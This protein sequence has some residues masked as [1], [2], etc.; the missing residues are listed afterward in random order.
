MNNT[1]TI[2]NTYCISTILFLQNINIKYYDT[3]VYMLCY[4]VFNNNRY[5]KYF[6]S[7][8]GKNS[9]SHVIGGDSK[10]VIDAEYKKQLVLLTLLKF[11]QKKHENVLYIS[12]NKNEI[13]IVNKIN[14]CHTYYVKT[15]GL[16]P[17]DLQSILKK[18]FNISE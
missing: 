17:N 13:D 16:T 6:T 10:L 3:N 8:M 11:L 1:Y 5:D 7:Q 4:Y 15:Q 14:V 9:V 12:G 18:Y 2:C